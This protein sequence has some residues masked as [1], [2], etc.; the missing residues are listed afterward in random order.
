MSVITDSPASPTSAEDSSASEMEDLD[1]DPDIRAAANAFEKQDNA[2]AVIIRGLNLLRDKVTPERWNKLLSSILSRV[3]G[4]IMNGKTISSLTVAG[5]VTDDGSCTPGT[6]TFQSK[7]WNK[8][9][10]IAKFD[11][12]MYRYTATVYCDEDKIKLRKELECKFSQY[13]CLDSEEGQLFWDPIES[14]NY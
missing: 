6:F 12:R 5:H 9:V 10:A 3:N 13:T 14:D 8:V 2:E 7:T 1:F 11:I 4:L